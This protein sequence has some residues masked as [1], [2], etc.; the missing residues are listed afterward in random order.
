MFSVRYLLKSLSLITWRQKSPFDFLFS[1]VGPLAFFFYYLF[2]YISTS[3]V[4]FWRS[5][6][7]FLLS[8]VLTLVFI[9]FNSRWISTFFS[10]IASMLFLLETRFWF[11]KLEI[12][13]S[14]KFIQWQCDIVNRSQTIVSGEV[15]NT[16]AF[17]S[18]SLKLDSM[19]YLYIFLCLSLLYR[20]Y[21]I[22]LLLD[23]L[24]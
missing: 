23:Q 12:Y 19:Q 18:V 20:Q 10:F 21:S 24:F 17:S 22:S 8:F 1:L 9:T 3:C 7:L 6:V 5:S 11:H 13:W 4:S 16:V 15:K 2:D 14:A